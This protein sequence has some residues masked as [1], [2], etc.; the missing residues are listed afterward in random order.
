M[1]ILAVLLGLVVGG[2]VALLVG[3]SFA[4]QLRGQAAVER[5]ATVKAAVDTVLAVAGDRLGQQVASGSRELD[6]HRESIGRQLHDMGG[7]LRRVT[8]LVGALQRERAEQHGQLVQGLDLAARST[9]DLAST[10]QSLRQALASPKARGQWGE[11]MAD[12][13]LRLAGLVEGLNYRKQTAIE[14]GTVPDF[15]FLLPHDLLLHLDVK[16]PVDNYLRYL[17]AATEAERSAFRTSFLRDVRQ[18]VK[19]LSTRG[20]CN[21]ESTVGYVL[22]FI[23]NEAVYGFIHEHDSAVVDFALQQKVVLCS[24][25]TLFAVLAVVRQA[26]D[27]FLLERTSDEILQGL[28]R[29]NQQ[30]VKFGDQID[31]VGKRLDS[32]HNAFSDLAGTR[33]RQ[34]QRSL[35]VLDAIRNRRGLAGPEGDGVEGTSDLSAT[36]FD[37]LDDDDEVAREV[38]PERGLGEVRRLRKASGQ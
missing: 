38:G 29:F 24:P 13:V 10:T 35:D 28:G 25:F 31:L 32:A 30:W 16:F 11:R 23:P 12:D 33:R 9:A 17:E 5:E 37:G 4:A 14:G 3:R 7:E 34:L 36:E 27:S 21:P 18:R 2:A 19:E 6:L 8:D 22:L 15:T 26:V 20:Y 1:L